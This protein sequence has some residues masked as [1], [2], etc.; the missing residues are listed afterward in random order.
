MTKI[1]TS[2]PGLTKPATRAGSVRL[3]EIATLS[4]G[5]GSGE[6]TSAAR[7]ELVGD[8]LLAR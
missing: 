5:I 1:A 7:A 4:S 8:D 6:A 3:T 2:E